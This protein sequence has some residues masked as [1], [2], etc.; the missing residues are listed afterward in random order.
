LFS[1][2]GWLLKTA[3]FAQIA[4]GADMLEEMTLC[5]EVFHTPTG[6]A[7]ADLVTDGHRETWPIRSKRFRTWVQ[8]AT[9]D[10]IVEGSGAVFEAKF[11]LPWSFSEE[12]AAEKHMAQIQH[13]MWVANASD[14]VL[15]RPLA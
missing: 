11:M 13:N 1:A 5:E 15:W 9:L 6:V 14:A 4:V 12:A 3:D 10:G 7:F 8:A 2:L